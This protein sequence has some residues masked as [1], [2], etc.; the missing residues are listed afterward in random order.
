MEE[1]ALCPGS[2]RGGC[3]R[4]RLSWGL[5]RR[6]RAEGVWVRGA[7][8][9]GVPRKSSKRAGRTWEEGGDRQVGGCRWSLTRTRR[10]IWGVIG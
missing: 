10:E 1:Q 3:V 2:S 9:K 6:E 8:S 5:R 7:G 4:K